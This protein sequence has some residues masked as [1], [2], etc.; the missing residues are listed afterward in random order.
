MCLNNLIKGIKC[1]KI[2]VT[3]LIIF[4]KLREIFKYV[5][6]REY[7]TYQYIWITKIGLNV[8]FSILIY[9]DPCKDADLTTDHQLHA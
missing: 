6:L 8:A 1:L 9:K 3:F 7:Y 5:F 2:I 4:C